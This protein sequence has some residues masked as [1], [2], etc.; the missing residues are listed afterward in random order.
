MQKPIGAHTRSMTSFEGRG[1]H[2]QPQPPPSTLTRSRKMLRGTA[3]G[4][5]S[6]PTRSRASEGTALTRSRGRS[7]RR[8]HAAVGKCLGRVLRAV[9]AP[10]PGDRVGRALGDRV[11]GVLTLLPT[12]PPADGRRGR[13]NWSRTPLLS[14]LSPSF[15][16]FLFLFSPSPFLF[17]PARRSWSDFRKKIRN[18]PKIFALR[19]KKHPQIFF[20][21]SAANSARGNDCRRPRGRL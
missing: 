17:P 1:A 11:V 21:A 9:R 14:P 19:A 7:H 15:L 10:A 20:A 2:T 6:T 3:S 18:W 13:R 8:S 4:P 16:F 12:G 5:P